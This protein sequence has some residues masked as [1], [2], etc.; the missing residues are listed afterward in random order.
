MKKIF[1]AKPFI[2]K[3]NGQISIV[4]P[5]KQFPKIFKDKIPKE[6]LI[7]LNWK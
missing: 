3:K 5:K 4:L 1:M 7:E 6:L 2:N